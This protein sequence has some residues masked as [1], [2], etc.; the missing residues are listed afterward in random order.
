MG[1]PIIA[2][3]CTANEDI[4]EHK[5]NCLFYDIGDVKSLLNCIK[6]LAQNVSLANKIAHNAW[7]KSHDFNYETRA[8]RLI[9]FLQLNV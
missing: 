6:E 4:F 3:R 9:E 2:A 8:K 7:E 1:K 5:I